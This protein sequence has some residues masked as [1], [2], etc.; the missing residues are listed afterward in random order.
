MGYAC[1]GLGTDTGGSVRIPAALNGIV[2]F[3]PTT[4]RYPS[5]GVLPLSN[6]R[7]TI[8]PMALNVTDVTLLDAVK[9]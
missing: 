1:V 6:T 3:W 2:G 8:G 4:G 9:E 5:D 7:D